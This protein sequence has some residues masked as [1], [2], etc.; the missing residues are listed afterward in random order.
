MK[1]SRASE[2]AYA[3]EYN[4][5]IDKPCAAYKSA[6]IKRSRAIGKLTRVINYLWLTRHDRETRAFFAA[7][8]ILSKARL[9]L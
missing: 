4:G 3:Q 2:T 5:A 9:F 6:R 1:R 7:T 8:E